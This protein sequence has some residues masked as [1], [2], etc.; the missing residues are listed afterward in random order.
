MLYT[1]IPLV[2]LV[3]EELLIEGHL[4]PFAR[5]LWR[6]GLLPCIYTIDA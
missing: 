4:W 5:L 6:D 2:A 1:L 3:K